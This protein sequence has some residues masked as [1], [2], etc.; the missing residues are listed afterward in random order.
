MPMFGP[1][2]EVPADA[3][4]RGQTVDGTAWPA[5][6][7]TIVNAAA[8]ATHLLLSYTKVQQSCH[9][10]FRLLYLLTMKALWWSRQGHFIS[11]KRQQ[12]SIYRKKL[13]KSMPQ[14]LGFDIAAAG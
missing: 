12:S 3:E 9:L 8:L 4:G 5:T 13:L 10:D 7:D 14:A 2:T 11:F 1:G 6:C